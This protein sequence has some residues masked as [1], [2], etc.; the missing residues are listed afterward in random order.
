M[1][2]LAFEKVEISVLNDRF[3]IKCAEG[4]SASYKQANQKVNQMVTEMKCVTNGAFSNER[5]LALVSVNLSH[6][7]QEK[8]KEFENKLKVLQSKINELIERLDAVGA[9]FS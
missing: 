8:D 2:T 3:T 1:N 6:E 7:L 9:D 5:I 4:E